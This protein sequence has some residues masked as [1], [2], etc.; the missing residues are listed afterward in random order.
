MQ[1]Q[2]HYSVA[3]EWSRREEWRNRVDNNGRGGGGGKGFFFS[4]AFS[5]FQM[6]DVRNLFAIE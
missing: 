1:L 6:V 4:T 3:T 5:L 2:K